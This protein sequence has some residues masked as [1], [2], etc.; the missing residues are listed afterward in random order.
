MRVVV[1]IGVS[2]GQEGG[3]DY[4]GDRRDLPHPDFLFLGLVRDY[5]SVFTV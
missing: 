2:F 1:I 3:G 5:T 4:E